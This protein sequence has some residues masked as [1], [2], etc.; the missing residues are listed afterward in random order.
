MSKGEEII[1]QIL[2]KE[3]IYFEREKTFETLKSGRL[4]FDFYIPFYRGKTIVIEFNGMQHYTYSS[5]FYK[6]RQAW[7]R[8]KENDRRKISFCLANNIEIFIIP[9]W[10]RDKLKTAKDLF[11][12]EYRALDKW[13]NDYTAMSF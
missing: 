10:D 13:K 5:F 11:K 9:E 12:D 8:Q 7:L 2:K 4:R 1:S 6:D 3:R